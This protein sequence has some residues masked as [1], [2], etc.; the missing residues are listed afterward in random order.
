MQGDT[1]SIKC[2][3]NQVVPVTVHTMYVRIGVCVLF[4]GG[5]VKRD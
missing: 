2:Q 1:F 3:H 5:A 4:A